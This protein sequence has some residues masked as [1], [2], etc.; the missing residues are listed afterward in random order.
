MKEKNNILARTGCKPNKTIEPSLK[1]L[2][3]FKICYNGFYPI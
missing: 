3:D 2:L 1:Y